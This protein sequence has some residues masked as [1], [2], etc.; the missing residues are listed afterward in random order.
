MPSSGVLES[1]NGKQLSIVVSYMEGETSRT[2][3][4]ELFRLLDIGTLEIIP[5]YEGGNYY[6]TLPGYYV[7]TLQ[8]GVENLSIVLTPGENTDFD[9]ER[10]TVLAYRRFSLKVVPHDIEK[11]NAQIVINYFYI[12]NNV[13]YHGSFTRVIGNILPLPEQSYY[14]PEEG[15]TVSMVKLVDANQED[16]TGIDEGQYYKLISDEVSTEQ[17]S[18]SFLLDTYC[19]INQ[20]N[21]KTIKY[22]KLSY[23][24]IE[25][26]TITE[27]EISCVNKWRSLYTDT[28][29]NEWTQIGIGVNL[30]ESFQRN[31]ELITGYYHCIYINGMAVKTVLIDGINNRPLEYDSS[32]NLVLTVG[33][34][35]L[36]QKCFLY[37][38]NDGENIIYPNM[39]QG[40]PSIIYNNYKSHRPDFHEPDDLPVLKFLRISNTELSD[41]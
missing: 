24:G 20:Q 14:E 30:Q 28:P 34:G 26:A 12:Y 37:Y 27:D 29:I 19:K 17:L 18:S 38:R 36:V 25:I 15:G 21:D 1:F 33:N 16:Y 13:E 9:F 22:I 31:G 11:N 23:G 39:P 5:E 2:K 10:S 41:R 8:A 3:T 4:Q 6:A 35:I 40:F 7:F 32:S